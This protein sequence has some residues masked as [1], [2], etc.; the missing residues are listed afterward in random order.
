MSIFSNESNEKETRIVLENIKCNEKLKRKTK[1]H[2]KQESKNMSIKLSIKSRSGC[3]IYKKLKNV[4]YK[5]IYAP[6]DVFYGFLFASQ[7]A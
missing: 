4:M 1:E 7:Q 6:L 5:F 3:F 2:K